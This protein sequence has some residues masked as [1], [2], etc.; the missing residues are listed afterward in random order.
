MN[1][2]HIYGNNLEY[3]S[4]RA[5]QVGMS[6]NDLVALGNRAA[7]RFSHEYIVQE[8]ARNAARNLMQDRNFVSKAA[9][10]PPEHV[11]LRPF[12]FHDETAPTGLTES[13]PE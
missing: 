10:L 2:V 4:E 7:E 6:A 12:V 9:S 8:Q 3:E 5:T 1:T 11:P 13:P